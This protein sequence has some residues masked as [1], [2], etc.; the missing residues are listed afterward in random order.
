MG[1]FRLRQGPQQRRLAGITS[2]STLLGLALVAALLCAAPGAWADVRVN[3]S[4]L[5]YNAGAA[6]ANVVTVT[7]T[8]GGFVIDDTGVAAIPIGPG[9][10]PGPTA[11]Q[12]ICPSAGIQTISIN[13]GDRDD[14][15]TVDPAITTHTVL[16]G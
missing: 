6:E 14:R 1:S 8:D 16:L 11:T 3:G 5:A 9:C 13:T 4:T 7:P 12:A 10:S 15:I 2:R